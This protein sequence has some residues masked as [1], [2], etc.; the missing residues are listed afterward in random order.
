MRSMIKAAEAGAEA[1]SL[2]KAA[3]LAAAAAHR[4]LPPHH[5]EATRPEDAYRSVRPDLLTRLSALGVSFDVVESLHAPSTRVYRTYICVT[6]DGEGGCVCASRLRELIPESC[7]SLLDAESL[8]EG[9]ASPSVREGLRLPPYAMSR[10]AGAGSG[11]FPWQASH[12][13]HGRVGHSLPAWPRAQWPA[14]SA[15]YCIQVAIVVNLKHADGRDHSVQSDSSSLPLQVERPAD[16]HGGDSVWHRRQQKGCT[17]Q[18]AR[19]C[20][21]RKTSSLCYFTCRCRRSS[22][23][24]DCIPS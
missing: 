17:Q 7:W 13:L 6:I 11:T 2:T 3:V 12:I 18:G 10:C 21:I 8:L 22:I 5:S 23:A 9:A 16:R 14:S 15:E 4:N 24:R 20:W 1:A 19:P